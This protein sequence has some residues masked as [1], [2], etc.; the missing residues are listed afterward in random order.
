MNYSNK[1]IGNR[2]QSEYEKLG[3]SQASFAYV[4]KVTRQTVGKWTKGESLPALDQLVTMCQKFKEIP[5]PSYDEPALDKVRHRLEK[6]A[7]KKTDSTYV[8][9]LFDCEM[10]YLLCEE[11]CENKTRQTTDICKATGLSEEAVNVLQQISG[12]G[13]ADKDQDECDFFNFL[14]E[15]HQQLFEPVQGMI[16][17]NE[18]V[19]WAM[20]SSDYSDIE[21]IYQE[22]SETAQTPAI[23]FDSALH[24][25]Y[26]KKADI[27]SRDELISALQEENL[28]NRMRRLAGFYLH[29]KEEIGD[30]ASADTL[31]LRHQ[32]VRA[33]TLIGSML[34]EALE[35]VKN[36]SSRWRKESEFWTYDTYLD[37]VKEFVKLDEV[38]GR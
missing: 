23:V 35:F 8:V 20:K 30:I 1:L 3:Y 7:V 21:F 11:G 14:I 2:I 9:E 12:N 38:K 5:I 17:Y 16:H 31:V 6:I 19:R 29:F 27:L 22:V 13:E 36:P 18:M 28:E 26:N 32:F 4:M 24:L 10:G 33:Y 25:Y 34:F 15:H 37:L